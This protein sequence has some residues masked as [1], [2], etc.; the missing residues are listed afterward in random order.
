MIAALT[1]PIAGVAAWLHYATLGPM[2]APGITIWIAWFFLVLL[3]A[4]A[5]CARS[6][7]GPSTA[8]WAIMAIGWALSMLTW[9]LSANPLLDL[10]AKNVMIA[11]LLIGVG[12]W[13]GRSLIVAIAFAHLAL[14]L[15]AFMSSIGWVPGPGQ[16]PRQFVAYSYP[17]IAAGIQHVCLVIL[18]GFAGGEPAWVDRIRR[19]GRGDLSRGAAAYLALHALVI[20]PRRRNRKD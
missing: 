19:M 6:Q 4:G 7:D 15:V 16:R 1:F 17:D 5:D 11:A 13:H 20:K 10:A 9:R 3:A 12:A 18:G 8:A 14:I 2:V